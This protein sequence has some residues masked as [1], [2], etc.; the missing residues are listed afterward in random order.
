MIKKNKKILSLLLSLIMIM[1]MFMGLEISSVAEDDILSYLS[2]YINKDHAIISR[3]NKSIVGDIVIPSEIDGFPVTYIGEQAFYD[4]DLIKSITIPEG[5]TT[6]DQLSF[7]CC[8]SLENIILPDSLTAIG[9]NAFVDSN[10]LKKISIPKNVSYLGYNALS[11]SSLEEIIVDENNQYFSNDNHG[12]L[13]NKDK[14]IIRLY[15]QGKTDKT[16]KIPSSV[17][18]LAQGVFIN[19]YLEKIIIPENITAISYDCFFNCTNLYAVVLSKNIT[20]IQ[21]FAFYN[22]SFLSDIRIPN[23]VTSIGYGAFI[24]CDSITSIT[25]PSTVTTIAEKALGYIAD[26]SGNTSVNKDFVI[27]GTPGSAAEAYAKKNGITFI[28]IAESPDK[29]VC[30]HKSEIYESCFLE[31]YYEAWLCIDCGESVKEPV[32]KIEHKDEDDDG[33]CDRMDCGM[34]TGEVDEDT[35]VK[36]LLKFDEMDAYG[37]WALKTNGTMI[38]SGSWANFAV[39]E[40]M[41]Y[42][43]YSDHVTQVI[44]ENGSVT[45]RLSHLGDFVNM[46][47]L[48]LSDTIISIPMFFA[49]DCTYLE[50]VHIFPSVTDIAES[51]FYGCNSLKTIYFYGTQEQWNKIEIEKYNEALLNAEIVFVEENINDDTQK[52]T[53]KPTEAP[54][55]KPVSDKLEVSDDTIK[56][57]NTSK[58]TTVKVKSSAK[59]ILSSVKNENVSIVDKDGKAV[60][61]DALVGTGAKIQIKDNS[62]NVINTYTVCVPTDVDGNGKTSAA[63]ARLA[64]RCSAKLEKL[65]GVYAT[66]SD[67]N[68]DNKITAADARMILRISAGLEKA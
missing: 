50:E 20:E 27:K 52:P 59:D 24:G 60:S 48:T 57:D 61:G 67:M 5:V 54:T 8:D 29:F 19:K 68:A 25:I 37:Q 34:W 43:R 38:F 49:S 11:A 15:P 13:F 45:S 51:A 1:S 31:D 39:S 7:A 6:I 46:K 40:K 44:F 2:Y 36:G 55:Q 14:T 33:Y 28:D 47:K 41:L 16:Y 10:S 26:E 4:C 18:A 56:V 53:E 3:C 64:L 42:A 66:A 17:T 62:G 35:V 9:G 23:S 22:C 12:V 58:V 30:H 65:E 32:I 63:D 21:D